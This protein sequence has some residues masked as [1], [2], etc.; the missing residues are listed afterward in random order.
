MVGTVE[1]RKGHALAFEALQSLW[2]ADVDIGLTIVGKAG[3]LMESLVE[4]FR[5]HP[6]GGPPTELDRASLQLASG[7]TLP[8]GGRT[9]DGL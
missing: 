3:W 9:A 4:Q 7:R 5:S 1:P 6:E 2:A 8:L